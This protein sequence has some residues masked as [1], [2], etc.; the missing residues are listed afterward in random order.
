MTTIDPAKLV[1]VAFVQGA[2]NKILQAAK[3]DVK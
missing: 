1:V 3:I 2:G